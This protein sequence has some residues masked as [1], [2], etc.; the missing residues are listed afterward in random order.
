MAGAAARH[1]GTIPRRRSAAWVL[2]GQVLPPRCGPIQAFA[3]AGSGRTS[4]PAAAKPP[5][6]EAN[7]QAMNVSSA[8][9]GLSSPKWS[10]QLLLLSGLEPRACTNS[11]SK[12]SGAWETAA[13]NFSGSGA[14]QAAS[15]IALWSLP[16][17]SS[18]TSFSTWTMMT[19]W[20][21]SIMA[22]CLIRQYRQFGPLQRGCQRRR[23]SLAAA[24]IR[25]MRR[26]GLERFDAPV[27][28]RETFPIGPNPTGGAYVEKAF[29]KAPEPD[30]YQTDAGGPGVLYQP[31]HVREVELPLHRFRLFPGHGSDHR[32]DP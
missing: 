4:F 29:L 14:F 3:Y 18:P 20:S 9:G 8:T 6:K 28:A 7:P 15:A 32:V 2:A 25:D 17:P 26:G 5:T 13:I 21:G 19:V 23:T 16:A 12:D 22:R 27:R 31:V 1:T 24:W 11:W 30:Q 10:A